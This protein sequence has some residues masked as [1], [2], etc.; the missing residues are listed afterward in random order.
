MPENS[1]IFPVGDSKAVSYMA[2]DGGVPE[3]KMVVTRDWEN[4]PGVTDEMRILASKM[5][6]EIDPAT[7]QDRYTESQIRDAILGRG[8]D[9]A[10]VSQEKDKK[11]TTNNTDNRVWVEREGKW[12]KVEISD[13]RNG[14][15]PTTFI[16]GEE[17]SE[18]DD[19]LGVEVEV[20]NNEGDERKENTLSKDGF[21]E[22]VK[23]MM[24]SNKENE[25]NVQKSI[26]TM[27]SVGA[28]KDKAPIGKVSPP[29]YVTKASKK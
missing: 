2:G 9:T 24:Y 7:N 22:A 27:K 19:V 29:I 14:E 17:P 28:T 12:T 15:I 21:I 25:D 4:E 11:D 26:N 23:L 8:F 5:R 3:A 13:V 18:G 6:M 10:E 1:P 20:D 16:E